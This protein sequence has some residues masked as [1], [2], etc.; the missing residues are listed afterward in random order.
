M[1]SYPGAIEYKFSSGVA[2]GGAE[3]VPVRRLRPEHTAYG[4]VHSKAVLLL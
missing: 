1:V 4:M 3:S 2:K